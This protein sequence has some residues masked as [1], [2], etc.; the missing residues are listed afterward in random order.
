MA[1]IE[2]ARLSDAYVSERR[3][4]L[5]SSL[6]TEKL[7][8]NQVI[9]TLRQDVLFLSNTPPVSGIVRAALNHGY[10]P[11][12]GNTHRVWAERLEQIF[13]AFS[14]AHPN[15]YQIRY[16]GVADGGREIVRVDNH[17]GKIKAAPLDSLQPKGEQGYFK[18]TL[19]LHSGEIYLSE[20]DLNQ[21]DGTSEQPNWPTLRAATPV[22]TP[23]GKM[24]GMV[25]I[26]MD[27]NSLLV[28]AVSDLPGAQTYISNGAGQYLLHP[29]PQQAFKFEPG[30]K[31][32]IATDFPVVETMFNPQKPDYLPLENAST[33]AGNALVSAQRIYFAPGDQ[34]RFLVLLY[35]IPGDVAA[36]QIATIPAKNI[37]G[38]FIAM[39]LVGGI[40]MLVLR[41][42]F[43]PLEKIATAA[44]KIA[45]G[46]HDILLPQYS[47]GEI[48]SLTSAL[49]VM[50]TQLSLREKSLLESES[51][52][53]RL[54]ESIRDAYVV[55]DMSGRMLEFN[56]TYREMLGYS[57][58]ELL[59]LTCVELSPE[60]WHEY[61]A[62]IIEEQ[63]IAQGYSQ[64]YEKEYIRKDG[65][66]FPVEFK[67]FLLRDKEG[68]PEAMWAIVRDIT[69]RQQARSALAKYKRGI[70]NAID[71]FWITDAAGNIREANA[72]YAKISGYTVEELVNMHISQLEAIEQGPEEVQAHIAKIV[73]QG[74]D[75]FETRH[76][77]KDGHE[78][79]IEVAVTS[80]PESRQLFVFCQ[81]ITERKHAADI[82]KKTQLNLLAAQQLA[83]IGS[84]EWDVRNNTATWSDE[85]YRLFE[86]DKGE[87]NEHRKNFLNMV[88]PEERIK[89][90][91]ALS[92]ALDGVKIYDI[93]Y[94]IR[95]A[96]GK[97]KVI[98]ALGETTRD[99]EGKV[100]AMHGTVQDITER[101]QAE[102]TLRLHSEI[103][104]NLLEGVLMVRASDGVIVYANLQ[105]ECMF[106]YDPGEI[107]G[108]H[109]SIV[110]A[111]GEA[112][113]RER[114]NAIIAE[115]EDAGVWSGE[116]RN[117]RKDGTAFWCHANVSAFAHPQFGKVWISVH[118]DITERKRAEDELQRF[119]DLIPDLACIASTGGHFVKINSAWQAV[120]GY[121]EQ[122][123]LSSPFLDFIHPD[124]RG[125]T[126]KEMDRQIGGEATLRFVNRYRC[127]DGSY[128]WLEWQTTP[129]FNKTLLYA[130][131]RDITARRQTEEQLQK[132]LGEIADL[133]N[134]APCGYHSLDK[135]GNI[136]R[137]NDTE[138]SWL[139]YTRG[140]VIG[141]MKWP[142]LLVPASRLLFRKTFPQLMRMG[143]IR[144]LEA[145]ITRKDGTIFTGL[146]NASAIYDSGGDFVMSRSTIIDITE[147]KRVERQLQELSAHL[148]TIREEEKARIAREIHD[149][150]GG[151]LTAL[152]MDAYWLAKKL[153]LGKETEPY[154]KRINSMS[155]L[156][157]NAVGVTRR[158]ITDLRPT[159]LDDLGL[160]AALE[161][162]AAQFHKRT[163]I[164]CHVNGIE[165]NGKLGKQYSIA[166]F[167]I[168]QETLTN[169]ARHSGASQVE[170][171]FQCCDEEIML[172]ISDNGR[173][174]PEGHTAASTSYGMRGMCERVEQLGGK[175]KFD[176]SPGGGF[177]VTVT[178]PP[179]AENI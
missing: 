105:F 59:Q 157:D 62:R 175:I 31:N 52:Y 166:L 60:R 101:K 1:L 32:R 35:S 77:H 176:S 78:I 158:I 13:S 178:L 40:A 103:L 169:V 28:S 30:R 117:I 114:A 156:L 152:K 73:A 143:F 84:W 112:S 61:E 122:E 132:S 93:E 102:D 88:A 17:G 54:H 139:G 173:G 81:D 110:N 36:K 48:G 66:V 130:T 38:G 41:R 138:L 15:Y 89:V 44:D 21:G 172:S 23:S 51:R 115:L 37:I 46:D 151:T 159:I 100:V 2:N 171:E 74:Y 94:R 147:R 121:T 53:R 75:R 118:D 87:L 79:D 25:V 125:A 137:M 12:Y 109:V 19:G 24:F 104:R 10:D 134:H 97:E 108:K 141:K 56:N 91:Q 57:A 162:Q 58:E 127:K 4:H 42:T 95:L 18:T 49:N 45:A 20:F 67:A 123:M 113:Q 163:G 76:R 83:K 68:Q 133:Y 136:R 144:D 124:D 71:G 170:V 135:D 126:M 16:I 149:D 86:I 177:C 179:F 148:Q 69:E 39:L 140:E 116:V 55:V 111:P 33:S 142:D 3:A 120:L 11:R 98:H 64:V 8:L 22:Y 128:K 167:R 92:D 7:R 9:D 82:L 90:D 26:T 5:K 85:T 165:G 131:A 161:W 96:G 6:E 29:E 80:M 160:L 43:S 106:G 14:Q 155:Q 164:K 99:T 50:L 63:V 47:S 65:T 150:L 70:D 153:P 145:E 107:L 27:V 34:S 119:F 146:I 154:L 129:A 72:A 168:F 174:L